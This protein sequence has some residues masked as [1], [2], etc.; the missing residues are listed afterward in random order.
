MRRAVTSRLLVT[1]IAVACAAAAGGW[2]HSYTNMLWADFNSPTLLTPEVN[3]FVASA[4]SIVSLEK[5]FGRAQ[6]LTTEDAFIAA[7]GALKA[8]NPSVKTL[9]YFHASVDISGPAFAPC[10]ASGAYFLAHPELWLRDDNNATIMNGPFLSHDLTTGAAERYMVDTVVG[11]LMRA[12][13]LFDG[14]FADGTL[15]Q[16]YANVS[17]PREDA[18]NAAVNAVTLAESLALNA[19]RPDAPGGVQVIGNGLAQYHA[20]NPYYP[21]DDGM[22]MVP[23][24]DG[25]CVEHWA[26]FEMTDASNCSIIP[27]MV[28]DMLAR[29]AAVAAL[30]KTVLIKGWPGPVT[31]PITSLGPSWPASC[32]APAGSSH[33]ERGQQA[34]EWFTPAYA[35][36]LLAVEPTVFWS[37]SWWYSSTD[38]YYA[39]AT[40]ADA[41][42]TSAPI[43]WYPDLKRP[44]GEPAGPA[45]RVSG[46]SGWVYT[47]TFDH[48]VVTVDLANWRGA[49]IAW[50]L[51]SA[52]EPPPQPQ[53]QREAAALSEAAA[54]ATYTNPVRPRLGFP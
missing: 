48:A 54:A 26:A 28:E 13:A 19:A 16:P 44:L 6:N 21:A 29:I 15:S 36:F 33:A 49:T 52:A 41:N 3:D 42:T 34:L 18:V 4:Y 24:T 40:P 14:V 23:F 35:L 2:R 17:Q 25:V 5:C 47:R 39:P 22:G 38:G 43:G 30:N 32:G 46:G 1:S 51:D 27:A 50:Q 37:Y 53:A 11:V 20:A 31:T 7:A 12:P 45:A 10:Y 9:F 8:A